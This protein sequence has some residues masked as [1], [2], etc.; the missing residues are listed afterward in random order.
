[1]DQIDASMPIGV[2]F[3]GEVT[4]SSVIID[5]LSSGLYE[6]P[7][8]CIKELVNNSYDA[9]ATEVVLTVRPDAALIIIDDNGTGLD[10]VEF[11]THFQRI[12]R[13]HKREGSDTTASGRPKIGKIGIGFVAANE[14]CERLEIVSTKRGTHDL[15]HVTLDFA[16]MRLDADQRRRGD[17]NVSKAD[18]YGIV[19]NEASL[20]D[21]YTRIFLTEV[22]E[23]SM[24]ILDG[25]R[26]GKGTSNLYGAT[27]EEVHQALSRS[28]LRSWSDFDLYTRSILEI[29]LNVPV[30]Y[31]DEWANTPAP[32]VDELT[33]RASGLNFKV[34]VDGT[35][36]RKPIVFPATDGRTL[37]RT[38]DW[39]GDHVSA[40]GYIYSGDKKLTPIE[41][42]GT[43]IRIRNSAV[44]NYDKSNLEYPGYKSPIFQ[45][46]VSVEIYADDRLEDALNIDRRTLRVTHPA[47]VEL[48]ELLHKELDSFF[49]EVRKELYGKRSEERKA[50]GARAQVV[51]LEKL[52]NELSGVLEGRQPQSVVDRTLNEQTISPE[53][54]KA[55]ARSYKAA[56]VIRMV[57]SAAIEAGI[58][59]A[60]VTRMIELLSETLLRP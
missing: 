8:A 38:V 49:S 23:E 18:Y 50:S 31:H 56:D 47:Y 51:E 36:L 35:E 28:T 37:L 29:G 55:L 41:L 11:E 14:I 44:G 25:T 42:N 27:R 39:K 4:V 43:L 48:Q 40:R 17:G 33:R 20:D 60:Q 22:K 2:E 46:W 12:A 16:Q 9:D 58:P 52:R 13:S 21:Q 30:A 34:T 59:S 1:M 54:V 45:D 24:R 53:T 7:A 5:Q 10:Q 3:S 57:R 19:S 6:S 26:T 15:M 32:I